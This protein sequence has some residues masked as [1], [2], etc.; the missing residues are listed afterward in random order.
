MVKL[1]VANT[2]SFYTVKIFK[3]GKFGVANTSRRLGGGAETIPQISRLKVRP[4]PNKIG[5]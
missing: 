5:M 1:G 2:F 4:D 3:N